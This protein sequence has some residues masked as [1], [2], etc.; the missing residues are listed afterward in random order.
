MPMD[1]AG[2]DLESGGSVKTG[3]A[4]RLA[5]GR[6]VVPSAAMEAL[7]AR[8]YHV[9]RE[10]HNYRAIN[11]L[12]RTV[13]PY[14]RCLDQLHKIRSLRNAA[15]YDRQIVVSKRE[16]GE[17]IELAHEVVKAVEKWL[18]ETRAGLYPPAGSGT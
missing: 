15:L 9:A 17:A 10:A 2:R 12:A 5:M 18:R 1:G 4:W 13:G 11:S 3:R 16:A 8:G 6:D 14:Q 7:A